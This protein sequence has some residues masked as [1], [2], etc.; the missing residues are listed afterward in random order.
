MSLLTGNIVDEAAKKAPHIAG[1][2]VASALS[3]IVGS[4]VFGL[5]ILR[6][7]F[8]VD[9]I[10]LP[11]IAAFMTGSALNI[12]MGQIPG[13]MGISGFSTRDAT[14]KVFIHT[15]Q[16]LGRSTLDAAMGLT[17]LAML[18]LIRFVCTRMARR[19]PQRQKFW[20]FLSTLRTAFVILLYTMIS[21]LVNRHHRT[22]PKFK[23][24]GKVPRGFQNMAVPTVNSEII[25]SFA[26]NIPVSVIVL[27]IE[28]IAI[29]KSFGRVNNYT[30]VPSQEL[31][32]IGITNVGQDF[33]DQIHHQSMSDEV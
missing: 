12:A 8:I 24:L 23:I 29:S 25:S 30:I 15:L 17:A 32:A 16:H 21:W 28:H 9:F 22:H 13:L 10:P 5:G 14:Y 27:L 1:H 11:A 26:N 7:G 33:L 31:I 4:I 19:F 6:L 20:F 3:V 18:Y 2:V